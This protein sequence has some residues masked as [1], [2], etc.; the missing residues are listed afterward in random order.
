M[1]E[2]TR[3]EEK[4]GFQERVA[5][6]PTF[7]LR[8]DFVMVYGIDESMPKR[9]KEWQDRGYVVHLMTGVA[10]GEYQ[11]YLYGE[12]DGRKH[13][14]EAQKNRFGD[15]ISHGKDVPYM[16]PTIAFT[17]YLTERI[18]V[19]VDAGVEAIHLEEPEFWVEGGYSEA[20]KRE[21]QIFYKEAWVP[22]HESVDAQYRASKLKAYLYTRCLDRLCAELKEYARVR[23]QR[24]LRFY[25]PTHSLINYTQWR[26][27]SPQSQLLSLPTVDGYIAQV[28]TGTSRTPNVYNGIRKERT[29]E[30]AYLEYGIMQELV[31][32]TER[33]MWF[34]HD[35][36]EDNPNYDW[37]D[38]RNN[39][40]KIVTASLF[41]PAVHRYEISP[42][43][44]RVFNGSYPK[45]NGQGKEAIPPDYATS[46]LILMNTLR[47]FDQS[48]IEWVGKMAP[49]GVLLADSTMFQR[50]HPDI[51]GEDGSQKYDGTD[52]EM[53]KGDKAQELLDWSEFYGLTFPLL[54]SGIPVRPVQLDNIRRFS[55]Y[56]DDY[57]TLI[58]SYEFLKPEAPDIHLGLS[59]WVQ[60]GGRLLYVGDH[61]DDY[62]HVREWW[63]SNGS[64]YENPAEHLF[65]TLGLERKL[66]Q[67]TYPVGN[68]IVSFLPLHPKACAQNRQNAELLKDTVRQ[69]FSTNDWEEKNY[70]LLKRGPY[71]ISAVM[72]E[73]LSEEPLKLQGVYVDLF[74]HHLPIR[75][76][77]VVQPGKQLLLYDLNYRTTKQMDCQVIASSS[78]VENIVN[79]GSEIDMLLTG[80][81][82][83][84]GISRLR[85]AKKPSKIQIKENAQD[86]YQDIRFVWD[87]ESQTALVRYEN[88]HDGINMKISP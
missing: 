77:V 17:N 86:G 21:W 11:D 68:G 39:Y 36:I 57:Q 10:W 7:D 80:P 83:I 23:Y 14:D 79:D 15:I 54:K 84:P 26:I 46:L 32:G 25:V 45:K 71:I 28:W 58:L 40:Y 31:R 66:E 37:D 48:E 73:S 6:H 41:H 43:P 38:Y 51:L 72:D 19:A 50:N 69:L 76:E 20:F 75:K 56:L 62:H 16:V 52:A 5:Y 3:L 2:N 74:D 44:N 35:P 67:G 1:M 9:I 27:V 59:Q 81:L 12:F 82:G 13:W 34:L 70:L 4:T 61:S 87:Q 24:T 88:K 33:R 60:N 22:P 78:R 49:I 53:L 65:E 30:T 63:N 47:D 64:S 29:F 18:K 42:W 8:T 85:F 55:S